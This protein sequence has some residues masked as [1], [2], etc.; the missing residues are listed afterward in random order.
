MKPEKYK[1]TIKEIKSVTGGKI[2]VGANEKVTLIEVHN[3]V[4]FVENK[5]GLIYPT[6]L[7]N[8]K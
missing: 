7:N 6:S 3:G 1:T 4:A 5:D 8:L 2:W